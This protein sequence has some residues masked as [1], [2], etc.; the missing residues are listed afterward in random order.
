V[1]DRTP[2]SS[3]GGTGKAAASLWNG[4]QWTAMAVGAPAAGRASLFSAVACPRPASC[5]AVGESNQY[6]SAATTTELTG[7]LTRTRWRLDG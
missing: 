3:G 5:V 2:G 1:I 4:Q 6:N 7:F